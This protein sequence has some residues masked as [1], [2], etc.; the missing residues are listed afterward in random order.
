MGQREKRALHIPSKKGKMQLL[1]A[2]SPNYSHSHN[3]PEWEWR[4]APLPPASKC[5]TA[6]GNE[7]TGIPKTKHSPI[8]TQIMWNK[9]FYP[10]ICSTTVLSNPSHTPLDAFCRRDQLC[11]SLTA[12][13]RRGKSQ[14]WKS[15]CV[16][17]TNCCWFQNRRDS[18]SFP[19]SRQLCR[20]LTDS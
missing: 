1:P 3:R 14:R 6:G 13:F 12:V 8:N 15:F 2:L 11:H 9:M 16:T 5:E 18:P 17:V 4:K 7:H 19:R 20:S 10:S